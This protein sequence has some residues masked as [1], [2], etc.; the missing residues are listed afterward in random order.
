MQANYTFEQIADLFYEVGVIPAP[1]SPYG[2]YDG[3][4][5]D[6]VREKLNDAS[7]LALFLQVTVPKVV[8]DSDIEGMD[9]SDAT[10]IMK[11][12]GF[13]LSDAGEEHG[14]E[15]YTAPDPLP[16]ASPTGNDPGKRIDLPDLPGTLQTLIDELEDNLNRQNRNA[17]AL[18]TRKIVQEAVFIAMDRRKKANALKDANGDDLDL[19]KALARC[20]QEY[21]LSGQVV[22]RV[23][24]AKWIGD[25]ANHSFRVKVNDAD[26]NQTVVGIRLFLEE[27][28]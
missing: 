19:E 28:L 26:L 17:A 14:V 22:S 15:D 5:R 6:Y 9:V 1:E 11:K 13:T 27:V 4:K 12:L 10:W 21:G 23:T 16:T 7:D 24:G 8:F 3:T 20:K 2:K 18:L 25:S